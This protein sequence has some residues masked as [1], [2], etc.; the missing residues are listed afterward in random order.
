MKY[1]I[2]ESKLEEVAIKYLNKMY[3][4]LKV[5]IKKHPYKILYMKNNKVYMEQDFK[6]R[7]LWVDYDTIWMDLKTIFSLEL[8]EIEDIIS[9]W[10]EETYKLESVTP[11][12]YAGIQHYWS[13]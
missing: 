1:I 9:K 2:T 7:D 13:Q 5:Y 4:D 12:T 10:A 6:N 8:T 3:G 11:V